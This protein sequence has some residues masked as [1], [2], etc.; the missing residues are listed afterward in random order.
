[1]QW[2]VDN[3]EKTLQDVKRQLE[4]GSYSF[5]WTGGYHITGTV[6]QFETNKAVSYS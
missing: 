1:M 3:D 5:E 6:K 2:A 4:D